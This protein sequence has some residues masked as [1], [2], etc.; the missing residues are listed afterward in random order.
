MADDFGFSGD[1]AFGSFGA[2]PEPEIDT[3]PKTSPARQKKTMRAD[4]YAKSREQKMLEANEEME[5]QEVLEKE[6]ERQALLEGGFGNAGD[7]DDGDDDDAFQPGF[8]IW[9]QGTKASPAQFV[10]PPFVPRD[11]RNNTAWDVG[12]LKKSESDKRV[13]AGN[14]GEF[15]IREAKRPERHVVCVNDHG[16]VFEAHIRHVESGYMFMSREFS[17]LASIVKHLQR[18]PLYNKQGLPLYIDKPLKVQ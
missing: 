2:S 14:H 5:Y 7:G 12:D 15:L 9:G 8:Q 1:D 3:V 11:K 13:M 18:N 4:I 17:D 16:Q 10:A 6:R